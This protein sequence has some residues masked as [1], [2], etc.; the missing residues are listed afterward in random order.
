M[1]ILL[2][3]IAIVF[4]SVLMSGAYLLVED[5][6]R[7]FILRARLRRENPKMSR[8]EIRRLARKQFIKEIKEL[9]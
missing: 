8:L 7:R 3:L 1:D 6:N 2:G 4:F 5:S 9:D